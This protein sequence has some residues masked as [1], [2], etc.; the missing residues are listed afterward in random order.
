M[1][2][3]RLSVFWRLVDDIMAENLEKGVE[4][5]PQGW[6]FWPG[7]VGMMTGKHSCGRPNIIII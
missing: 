7:E 1:Q 5:L 6:K 3:R 2:G 4:T